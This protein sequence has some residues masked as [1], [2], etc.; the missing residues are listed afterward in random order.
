MKE[1]NTE[2][3]DKM[4]F[5]LQENERPVSNMHVVLKYPFVFE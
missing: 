4:G 3:L 2:D 5:S 1:K